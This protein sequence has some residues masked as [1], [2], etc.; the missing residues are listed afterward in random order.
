MGRGVI[1]EMSMRYKSPL[2]ALLGS[3]SFVLPPL[4]SQR[5]SATPSSEAMPEPPLPG[6][7][8]GSGV[9]ETSS[10]PRTW[11]ECAKQQTFVTVH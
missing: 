7:Q 11:L 4:P 1:A 5:P 6:C 3:T 9:C 10:V 8:L 2:G